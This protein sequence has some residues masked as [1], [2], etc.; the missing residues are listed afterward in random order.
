MRDDRCFDVVSYLMGRRALYGKLLDLYPTDTITNA[1]A[2][3][4]PDGAD[5]IP[6]KALTIN[7]NPVQS[8]SGD[9]AP[10]NVRPIS[11]WTGASI[12]VESAEGAGDGSVYA[13]SWQTEAGTVYGGT[14]NVTTGVLTVTHALT[15]ETKD[16][17]WTLVSGTSHS[18]YK[19]FYKTFDNLKITATN[20]TDIVS[21]RL[22]TGGRKQ[23]AAA[24]ADAYGGAGIAYVGASSGGYRR[25]YITIPGITTKPQLG[26]FFESN[27]LDILYPLSVKQTVQLTPTEVTTLLGDNYITADTGDIIELTYRAD[28]EKYIEKKIGE[29]S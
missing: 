27:T 25:I 12:T 7:I 10:D 23:G 24:F 28:V 21:D 8:G 22:K 11:G 20:T 29:G 16:T 6:V 1:A 4:F 13:V 2:A 9:P 17:G 19:M 3:T 5:G 18:D 26:T 15:H 14:L